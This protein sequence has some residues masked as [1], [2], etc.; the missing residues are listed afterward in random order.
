MDE[1]NWLL[2]GALVGVMVAVRLAQGPQV[3][4]ESGCGHRDQGGFAGL[5]VGGVLVFVVLVLL[6]NL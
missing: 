3:I 1:L 4:I 5:V 6:S 2:F